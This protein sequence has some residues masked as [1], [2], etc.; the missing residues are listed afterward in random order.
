[1]ASEATAGAAPASSI[2][3]N[4]SE[5]EAW[6][7]DV[8]ITGDAVRSHER[9]GTYCI[10]RLDR[11]GRT[12]VLRVFC[13]SWSCPR[14]R[15]RLSRIWIKRIEQA[16][17]EWSAFM[18]VTLDPEKLTAEELDDRQVQRVYVQ[19]H[20]NSLRRWFARRF[21]K[22]Q[23][24]A[25]R[26]WQPRTGRLHMHVLIADLGRL[27]KDD[28]K[29][30]R[31]AVDRCGFGVRGGRY[32]MRNGRRRFEGP[33]QWEPLDGDLRKVVAY[34]AKYLTKQDDRSYQCRIRRINASRG[35]L[36]ILMP[37][38]EEIPGVWTGPWDTDIEEFEAVVSSMLTGVGPLLGT[39][40]IIE[41]IRSP[42]GKHVDGMILVPR[43]RRTRPKTPE[44]E[45]EAQTFEATVHAV[46]DAFG[47]TVVDFGMR[48][49]DPAS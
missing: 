32:R 3:G 29:A 19:K 7:R 28:L 4:L 30:V 10:K 49:D 37:A 21:G 36:P 41:K 6:Q 48:S 9:C 40:E 2:L 18:T 35:L 23:Y 17:V 34:L 46:A 43:L 31:A 39:H 27:S 45:H 13:K 26:E 22:F 24:V 12:H 25:V 15:K 42:N 5:S 38:F 20:W 11:W 16:D 14:C 33:F 1:V 44:E 47:G 8:V